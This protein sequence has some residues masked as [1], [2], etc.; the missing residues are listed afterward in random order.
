M[1]KNTGAGAMPCTHS[2]DGAR[3]KLWVFPLLSLNNTRRKL[4]YFFCSYP[5]ITGIVN[6]AFGFFL[7]G[8]SGC[9]AHDPTFAGIVKYTV[10]DCIG[11]PGSCFVNDRTIDCVIL[12]DLDLADLRTFKINV[13]IFKGQVF[14]FDQGNR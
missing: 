8:D 1:D 13:D 6:N 11:H 2:H 3:N 10:F 4:G 9:W 12:Q 14:I 7:K 5:N